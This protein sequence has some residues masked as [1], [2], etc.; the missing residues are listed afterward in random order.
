MGSGRVA[1]IQLFATGTGDGTV[2]AAIG[3]ID[4]QVIYL[5]PAPRAA[6]GLVQVNA[7]IPTEVRSGTA[8]PVALVAGGRRSQNHVTV[9]VQ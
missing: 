7:V 4:A 6:N 1:V 9:A 5:G 2:S 3:G 8:M